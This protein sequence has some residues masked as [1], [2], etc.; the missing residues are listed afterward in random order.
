MAT[1]ADKGRQIMGHCGGLPSTCPSH[2]QD[3]L[4]DQG[5]RITRLGSLRLDY[6]KLR[7]APEVKIFPSSTMPDG[8]DR[9]N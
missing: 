1:L 9:P 6:V 3:P 4:A 8:M 2:S 5:K 7:L